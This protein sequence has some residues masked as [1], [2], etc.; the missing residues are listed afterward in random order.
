M[1]WARER[2]QE[3]SEKKRSSGFEV[4]SAPSECGIIKDNCSIWI[5]LNED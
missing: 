2:K 4:S 1:K 5:I 3:K